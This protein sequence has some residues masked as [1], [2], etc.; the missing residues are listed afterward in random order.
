MLEVV[1]SL[2][3]V[4]RLYNEDQLQLRESFETA[5]IKVGGWCEM[6]APACEDA[7]PEAEERPLMEA[8]TKQRN[9]D[10]DSDL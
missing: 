5:A 8:V 1:F 2:R 4:P 10:S 6:A 7:S 9:K 3:S